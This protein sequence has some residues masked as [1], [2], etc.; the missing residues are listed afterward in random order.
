MKISHKSTL[1]LVLL[2]AAGCVRNPGDT[3]DLRKHSGPV[4]VESEQS[5]AELDEGR[6]IVPVRR[7]QNASYVSLGAVAR[8]TGY[9]ARWLPDG[10]YGMGDNDPSWVFRAGESRVAVGSRKAAMAGPALK[11]GDEL[12]VPVTALQNLFGDAAAFRIQ[13]REVAFFPKPSLP[14]SGAAGRRTEFS[15][16]PIGKS[17]MNATA[18]ET[19][20]SASSLLE[21]ARKY[22]GVQYV[23]GTGPYEQSKAFDCSSFTQHVFDR[24]GVELPRLARDQAEKGRF[25]SRDELQPG[26]LMFF[27]VP[28]RFKSDKT[29]GHVGI[30]MGN[31]NMIHA[32]PEPE[33]GVQV[34]P[35]DKPYWQDTYLYARRIR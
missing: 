11:E 4:K 24:F 25:V 33:D 13:D 27:Y 8:A 2:L 17:G 10:G 28:G 7:L 14:D 34:T 3:A 9:R 6:H 31:G 23:F 15:R 19:G 21:F 30:Y 26:D 35:I 1:L 12:F 16:K 29:V 18:N 5:P 32:S 20:G 22:I